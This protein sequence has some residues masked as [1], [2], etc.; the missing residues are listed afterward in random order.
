M[1]HLQSENPKQAERI[2]VHLEH[3]KRACPDAETP[4]RNAVSPFWGGE[5]FMSSWGR[6]QVWK[7]EKLFDHSDL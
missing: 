7:E 4:G 3:E 1:N 5:D 6:Y 2:P